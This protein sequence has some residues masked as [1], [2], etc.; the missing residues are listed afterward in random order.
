[1]QG[2]INK[3]P[4]FQP[5]QV[6][7]NAHLNQVFNYLDEQERLTRANTIGIGILCGLDLTVDLSA[8]S[9]RI[10]KGCGITS[11]GYL[12]LVPPDEPPLVAYKP[13]ALPE[14]LFYEQ[15]TFLVGTVPQQYPLWEMFPV[16][17]PEAL[18]LAAS[19]LRDKVVVLFLE[20]KKE[21]LR[22]CSPNNC[23]DRGM[24][25]QVTVRK[26][27]IHRTEMD[28]IIA[29]AN[30]L[31]SGLTSADLAA[32]LTARLGLADIRL[33]RYDVPNTNPATSE[34]VLAAF[35]KI[36]QEFHLVQTTG[37]ALRAA[38]TAF[39]PL[40]DDLY[41][42]DPFGQFIPRFGFLDVVPTTARQ[43]KF[44]Q[45]YYDFFD[46]LLK[47]YEE[48]RWA[49]AE[50]LCACC[51]PEGLFPRHL[52]LGEVA[53]TANAAIYRHHFLASAAISGCEQ[54]TENL[55][56]LFQRLVEMIER[57]TNEPPMPARTAAGLDNQIRLTPSK[58]ADVPLSAKCIPYYYTQNGTP[59]LYQLWN[60][61]KTRRE[62]ADQNLSYRANEYGSDPFVL[63]PLRYDLE[64][65]NFI[66]V[67]GHLQ[68]DYKSVLNTLLAMRKQYRLPF[69]VVALRTGAFDENIVVDLS[70]EECRF[71]DLETLY[72]TVK[73]EFICF[74]CKEVKYFYDLNPTRHQGTKTKAKPQLRLLI[75]CDPTY[76]VTLPSLGSVFEDWLK[77][78]PG[79]ALP[80][81]SSEVMINFLNAFNVGQDDNII[82]FIILC[83]AK[84]YDA[85]PADFTQF[86]YQNFEKRYNDLRTVTVAVE[87]ER[88]GAIANL[89]S[90]VNLLNWEEIDD[91]I[92][93][94][95]Y[96]CKSA[97]FKALHDEYLRRIRE[98]KQKQF[99]SFF[100]EKNPG[101]QHKA[102]FPLGGT[103]IIIYHEDTKPFQPDPNKPADAENGNIGRFAFNA[104]S[105]KAVSESLNRLR[106]KKGYLNDPDIQNIFFEMASHIPTA[107]YVFTPGG[108]DED[109]AKI[110]TDTVG[111]LPDGVVIADFFLPYICC[112]DCAPVQYVLPTPPLGLTVKLACSTR[113]GALATIM[114][115]GGVPPYTYQLDGAGAFQ[116]LL[117]QIL[118][119]P[120]PRTLVVSDSAGATSESQSLTVPFMLRIHSEGVIENPATGTYQVTF[121]IDGGT[122]PYK[123]DSGI[124][125]GDTYTSAPIASGEKLT[126]K[127][128]D[129]ALPVGCVVISKEFVHTLPAPCELPCEGKAVRCGY[130]FWLPEPDAHHPYR[131]YHLEYSEFSFE[132]P[133]GTW[134]PNI[135]LK[136]ILKAS[137]QQL[138]SNFNIVVE[139]W[140][141]QINERIVS[142]TGSPDWLKF[143]YSKLPAEPF[144]TLWIEHYLCL[145]FKLHVNSF[146][147]Q[148]NSN[149]SVLAYNP[150]GTSILNP[151][152]APPIGIPPFNCIEIDKCDPLRVSMPRC[153]EIDM[154]LKIGAKFGRNKAILDVAS[155]G[156]DQPTAFLWEVQDGIP[157]V[158][159]LKKATF[160]FE[161]AGSPV[162]KVRLT[163]FTKRGCAVVKEETITLPGINPNGPK[164]GP[165]TPIGPMPP[166]PEKTSPL[167]RA[168]DLGK[169]LKSAKATRKSRTPKRKPDE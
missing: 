11:Q 21:G 95:L 19:F 140:L 49:S 70:R 93:A 168:K 10:S 5:N 83:I 90:I 147:E 132:F 9:I 143:S 144:G 113:D 162:K 40:L 120:G 127:I 69:E 30:E 6:L 148:P 25:V 135:E 61:E 145:G 22:N 68:K 142:I 84:I 44:L 62:R 106:Y 117:G 152:G 91:R 101:I 108:L 54:Q 34:D 56:L 103:F 125:T 128:S 138:N 163:A 24:E 31:G 50:L 67:E 51:P 55:R 60:P 58:L 104:A 122:A 154:Q 118:I 20:L 102:G 160:T 96:T 3:F 111:D 164:I 53:P 109:T 114:P 47:A 75:D 76:K 150:Q 116:A 66:R 45:Y 99:L 157:A 33:P 80:E 98:V 146:F 37:D 156:K 165:G 107:Q 134:V 27:L 123:P 87:R 155:T 131:S 7:T 42:N 48:F 26:L 153:Q 97:A 136:D 16:G 88:E 124:V 38:Y 110:F 18:T 130:R 13:Y 151:N 126:V 159:N 8:P 65:Y 59:P 85:I 139:Y 158:S 64:P 1:M 137:H 166:A 141:K 89:E 86:N 12:I 149:N 4:V 133:Q 52:M 78:Q 115:Q 32:A 94:I 63:Q 73:A 23:D 74:L 81:V 46:D 169:A 71:Q 43:V 17:E 57:F 100:L 79:G 161:K 119:P 2:I 72:D 36:F 35:F 105:A 167:T 28:K 29:K 41:P 14:D 82:S 15:F 92:E 112:S 77:E 129:S 121:T 39:R